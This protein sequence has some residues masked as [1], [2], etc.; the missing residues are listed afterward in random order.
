MI[1]IAVNLINMTKK[2]KVESSMSIRVTYTRMMS[3]VSQ[4]RRLF[5]QTKQHRKIEEAVEKALL[6]LVDSTMRELK[7][8]PD[9]EQIEQLLAEADAA[10][11][12]VCRRSGKQFKPDAF[13]D[14][15]GYYYGL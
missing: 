12:E 2:G 14:Y 7:Y 4:A 8:V 9:V 5:G 6:E 1:V 10:W 11:R 15:I 13:N 3:M